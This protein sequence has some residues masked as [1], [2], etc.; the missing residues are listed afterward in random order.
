MRQ[1]SACIDTHHPP[2]AGDRAL[3]GQIV[4]PV[5][6]QGDYLEPAHPSPQPRR[7]R[8]PGS[9]H[10]VRSGGLNGRIQDQHVVMPVASCD[11]FEDSQG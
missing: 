1:G 8:D 10:P 5:V 9:P 11:V 3:V 7:Q 2:A 4:L 6:G